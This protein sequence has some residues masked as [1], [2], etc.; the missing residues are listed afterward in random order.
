MF[1]MMEDAAKWL[2]TCLENKGTGNTCK[3]SIPSSSLMKYSGTLQIDLL[4]CK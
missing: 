4:S 1:L 3:G 2:A